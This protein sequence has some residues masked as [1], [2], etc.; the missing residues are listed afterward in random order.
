M[1]VLGKKDRE[2]ELGMLEW[3]C[4]CKFILS[5]FI[6]KSKEGIWCRCRDSILVVRFI[7]GGIDLG[8]KLYRFGGGYLVREF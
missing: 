7:F 1:N 3:W 5:Y 2:G 6:G 4:C 8:K